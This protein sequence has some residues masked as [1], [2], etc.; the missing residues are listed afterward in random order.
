MDTHLGGESQPLLF[1]ARQNLA[2]ITA[3]DA[4][5]ASLDQTDVSQQTIDPETNVRGVD[6]SV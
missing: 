2:V 6:S 1:S 3:A 4:S 5:V